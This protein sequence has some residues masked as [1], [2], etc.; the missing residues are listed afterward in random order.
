[1]VSPASGRGL[2]VGRMEGRVEIKLVDRQRVHD[3]VAF[4]R[5]PAE[6]ALHEAVVEI[7]PHPG[8]TRKRKHAKSVIERAIYREGEKER[9][10]VAWWGCMILSL[11][12][13][14]QRAVRGIGFRGYVPAKSVGVLVLSGSVYFGGSRPPNGI[15]RMCNTLN[16]L[17]DA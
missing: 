4:V 14:G 3:D 6:E 15:I 11:C 5:L 2:I 17:R 9:L 8:D 13:I 12:Y 10:G 7:I 1:M 16:R